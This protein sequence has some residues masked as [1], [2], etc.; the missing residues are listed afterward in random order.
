MNI[1]T[2][3]VASFLCVSV[4]GA[5]VQDLVVQI[6]REAAE[7]AKKKGDAQFIAATL[8]ERVGDMSA[9]EVRSCVTSPQWTALTKPLREKLTSLADE[10]ERIEAERTKEQE[11]LLADT[12]AG[13]RDAKE[14]KDLESLIERWRKAQ[15]RKLSARSSGEEGT[16]MSYG[17]TTLL[18]QLANALQN[19]ETQQTVEGVRALTR[20]QMDRQSLP[21][22]VVREF[23]ATKARLLAKL[24][25]R[26]SEDTEKEMASLVKAALSATQPSE[27]DEVLLAVRRSE[28]LLEAVPEGGGRGPVSATREFLQV[29]QEFLA[30]QKTQ[31]TKTSILAGKLL[32]TTVDVPGIARSKILEITM[33]VP[34]APTGPSTNTERS[35]NSGK[36]LLAAIGE[37]KSL[38]DIA[39]KLPAISVLNRS[40]FGSGGHDASLTLRD[41]ARA[42]A[43]TK[44]GV[45][46]QPPIIR[47]GGELDPIPALRI[48]LALLSLSKQYGVEPEQNDTPALFLKRLFAKAR[49]DKDWS[50][51][52]RIVE[53]AN[54]ENTR[55]CSASDSAALQLFLAARNFGATNL[56]K[57][58][59]ASYV[60]ALNTGSE[61]LPI[62]EI[63]A[64][65]E[66]LR[67]EAQEQ[68]AAGIVLAEQGGLPA[69]PQPSQDQRSRP[70]FPSSMRASPFGD[71]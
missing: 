17:V 14:S 57:F 41:L 5:T 2:I 10:L 43:D 70:G 4:H 49:N 40:E 62:D 28:K 69:A 56:P 68:Y 34:V 54:A 19:I 24:G 58:A 71:R 27:I 6:S 32:S 23:S 63:R 3:L 38:A 13:I 61:L 55:L 36:A 15:T 46:V 29:W 12:I 8:M 48:E 26:S 39:P 11:L 33:A 16:P 53:S 51:I 31:S 20:V 52:G 9:Q 60:G 7:L 25:I 66:K 35:Q 30:A 18:G 37:I 67:A 59:V 21:S 65:L 1:R 50:A 45:L 44:A 47:V 42:Y 22:G 64:S